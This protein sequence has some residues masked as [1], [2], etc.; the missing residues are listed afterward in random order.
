MGGFGIFCILLMVSEAKKCNLLLIAAFQISCF[1]QFFKSPHLEYFIFCSLLLGGFY[2]V[3]FW[4]NDT[5]ESSWSYR[6]GNH[7]K[8]QLLDSFARKY[9]SKFF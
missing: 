9:S 8:L 5:D 3:F 2:I 6:L 4:W 7:T 1:S